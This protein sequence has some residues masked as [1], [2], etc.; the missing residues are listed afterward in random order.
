MTFLACIS[1]ITELAKHIQVRSGDCGEKRSGSKGNDSDFDF[2]FPDF[3]YAIRDFTLE[4]VIDGQEV[5]SDEYLEHTLTMK[6]GDRPEVKNFNKIRACIRKYFRHRKCFTFIPPVP[7]KC[8][9]LDEVSDDQLL[10]D[11]RQEA[12]AF[13]NCIYG[14]TP[15]K[16]INGKKLTGRSEL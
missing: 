2:Y 9:R 1:F 8:R 15:V 13:V 3:V 11:F 14:Q 5:T 6:T 4:L 16:Q 7:G 12:E 10:P